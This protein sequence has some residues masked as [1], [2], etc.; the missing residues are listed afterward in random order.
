M[1]SQVAAV[2]F[3]PAVL[4][5]VDGHNRQLWKERFHSSLDPYCDVFR[6][7]ILKSAHIVETLMIKLGQQRRKC[8][9]DIEKINHETGRW[10]DWPF[11]PKLDPIGV[12]MH[13]MAPMGRR[14][15]GEPVSGLE[16]ECL[17][18]SHGMPISLWV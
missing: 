18:N 11:E 12:A 6:S 4:R 8:S 10:L 2:A 14:N 7:R 1:T 3:G 17:C 5:L 13:P 15:I 9:L 16:R